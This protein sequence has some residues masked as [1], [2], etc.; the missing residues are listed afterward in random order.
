MLCSAHLLQLAW[1]FTIAN[2]PVVED[3][4][5]REDVVAILGEHGT[6]GTE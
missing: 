5:L 3:Y 1:Q 6:M 2:L 4:S